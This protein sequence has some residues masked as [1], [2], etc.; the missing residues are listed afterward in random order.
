MTTAVSAAFLT[1]LLTGHWDEAEGLATHAWAVA[2]LIAGGVQ[3][4]LLAAYVTRIISAWRLLVL[5]GIVIR[6]L[7]ACQVL[8]LL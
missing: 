1:A 4:A 8:R 5:V 6:S 3:V 2:G 7:A